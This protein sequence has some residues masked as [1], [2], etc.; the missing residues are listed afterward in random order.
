MRG[1]GAPSA[2]PIYSLPRVGRSHSFFGG[3]TPPQPPRA[4]AP[5]RAPG[6]FPDAGKVT[7]GAPRAAPFGIPR[8]VVAALFALAALRS[9]SRRATFCHKNRPICHFELSGQTGLFSP[10]VSAGSHPLLSIRS[11]AD[12]LPSRMPLAFLP[13]TNTTRAQGRGIKGGRS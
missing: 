6:D 12:S 9:V 7:K 1:G 8:C 10:L 3:A 5:P 13:A 4:G 2:L 11:A